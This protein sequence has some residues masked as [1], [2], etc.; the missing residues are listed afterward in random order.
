VDAAA[1]VRKMDAENHQS[2]AKDADVFLVV[3]STVVE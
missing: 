1:T 3:G 2:P